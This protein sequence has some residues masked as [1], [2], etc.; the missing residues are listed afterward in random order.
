M[1]Q[2]QDRI[3]EFHRLGVEVYGLSVDTH[4]AAGAWAED[5]GITFP[6][7]SDF[8]REAMTTLGIQLDEFA[9]YRQVSNR[10]IF[11][12]DRDGTLVYKDVIPQPRELPDAEAA[13]AKVR[14]MAERSQ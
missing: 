3:D 9:G 7:L 8:N 12:V 5:L 6:M 4:F 10:A 14:E 11:I 2:L 1:S 13:L